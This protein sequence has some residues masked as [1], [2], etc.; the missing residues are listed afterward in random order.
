MQEKVSVV[1]TTKNEEKNIENCLKSI[2]LQTWTNIEIIVV[3]NNSSDRTKEISRRYT[4]LVFDKGPERSAQRNYGLIGKARGKFAMFVDADMMMTPSLI[5]TCVR[6]IDELKSIALHIEEIVLGTGLLGS[7]R[8]YERSFYSGTVID[9]A[10]F[11]R[12]EDFKSIGGFDESLPPGPEDWDLD[13]KF[14][15]QGDIRLISHY[16]PPIPWEL[17]TEVGLRG[18]K[19]DNRFIGIYHNEADQTLRRYLQKKS[20]YSGSMSSY[21]AR[22]PNDSDV[23]KQLGI[24]YRF[25]V[26]FLEQGRWRKVLRQP[27]L[28]LFMLGLRVLVG[29][30]Y[31]R[32][33]RRSSKELRNIY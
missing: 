17:G 14:K 25:L 6:E 1:I 24:R 2:Q 8:R 18:V 12:R 9:G 19:Y 29:V 7:I 20:Y 13:K 22:W 16:G 4:E 32:V 23:A 3:D 21:V 30:N 10:R 5:E 26:V 33:Q 27:L 28:F 15:L 31:L 11:F